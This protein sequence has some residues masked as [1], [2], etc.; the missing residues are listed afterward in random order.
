MPSNTTEER[1]DIVLRLLYQ[2][3]PSG[4]E[5]VY[6]Y[7]GGALMALILPIVPK[8]EVAEEVLHDVLMKIWNGIDGYDGSKSR[9]FTWMAR[10]AK[11]AAIDRTR[12]KIYRRAGKTAQ[13]DDVVSNRNELSETPSTDYI[14]VIS[15][16]EKLDADHR[17]IIE[18]LYLKDYTQSEAAKELDVPLGTIKTRSRRAI[19]QLRKLLQ[20]EMGW[21]IPYYLLILNSL[22]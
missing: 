17:P 11:N 21:L 12:S 3:N 13:L 19:L 9:L 6:Q 10:I 8:K 7:Y 14:G 5:M 16:L 1:Q 22:A 20:H 2:R 18:L 15:L 4:M